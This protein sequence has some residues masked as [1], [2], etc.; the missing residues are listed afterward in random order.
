MTRIIAISSQKGG[1]GKTS[2]AVNLAALLNHAGHRTLIVDWDPQGNA[3]SALSAARPAEPP[4]RRLLEHPDDWDRVTTYTVERNLFL[5]P[6]AA[7]VDLASDLIDFD[8]DL[9]FSLRRGLLRSTDY[10]FVLI[11]SPPTLGPLGRFALHVADSAL[12][13]VQCE[14][15]AVQAVG[16][17]LDQLRE[18]EVERG[19]GLEVE[20]ILL[21]MFDEELPLSFEITDDLRE[22]Y[23][24]QLLETVIPRDV[25]IAESSGKG[26]PIC[27]YDLRSRGAW[28]YLRLAKEISS[29]VRESQETRPRAGLADSVERRSGVRR[30]DS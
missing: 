30:A 6:A 13:P 14:P 25:A 9:P 12:I 5:V 21:T 29:H 3:T 20:G 17:L 27:E 18:I 8:P 26:L 24:D 11:D 10:E 16:Q 15:F 2:T 7:P 22:R 1:V 23:P 4:L 28:A 19:R